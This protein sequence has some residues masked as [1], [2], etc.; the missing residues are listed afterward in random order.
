MCNSDGKMQWFREARYGMFIHWGLYA[1]PAGKWNEKIIPFGSEWIMKNARIP[2]AKYKELAEIFNPTSFNARQWVKLAADSGMKYLV[3]TAKHV[4]G[5]ALYDSQ[6]S[7]FNIVKASPFGRDVVKELVEECKAQGIVFCLYYSQYQDWEDPDGNGNDWDFDP[8]KKDFKRYFHGKVKPQIKELLTNYGPIGL[9]WFD[10]PYEMPKE[11][12]EELV[13]LV[14]T[15]QPD[16]LINGRVGYYLGDFREMGD[17]S[18]PLTSFY[19]DWETPMTLNDTWGYKD[20]DHN[21][22]SPEKVIDMLTDITGKYGNFLLNVGPDAQGNIPPE[23]AGILKTV[24]KWLE[25]NGESV[26]GTEP[27]PDLPYKLDWG[28]FTYKKGKLYMHIFEWP[29]FPHEILVYGFKTPVKKA[30]L[31]SDRERKP[32]KVIH[33]FEIGRDQYRLRVAVPEKPIDEPDTVVVL[34]LDG[35]PEVYN[36]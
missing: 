14:R 13:E 30:Y 2:V 5:F 9:L 8:E 32:L 36:T 29:S 11:Y 18:I 6:A 26:Y 31:L 4:D 15:I 12:C 10:T 35:E 7:D 22:K 21:F 16:C 27:F 17:N 34:E 24:G 33:T 25:I 1:I 3:F 28:R 20:Y 23:S 19:C